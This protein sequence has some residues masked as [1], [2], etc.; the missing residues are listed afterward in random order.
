MSTP[1]RWQSN[2]PDV[3]SIDSNGRITA[4]NAG[5]VVITALSG[6]HQASQTVVV[7]PRADAA[8]IVTPPPPP[9][10]VVGFTESVRG[11]L[12]AFSA[13]IRTDSISTIRGKITQQLADDL[14]RRIAGVR[15]GE[16][17]VTIRDIVADSAR[18]TALFRMRI[19]DAARRP[20]LDFADFR[21]TFSTSIRGWRLTSIDRIQ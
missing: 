2:D 20:L 10:T 12:A 9:P 11:A 1:V 4:K 17:N 13:A 15:A 6:G 8:K 5:S 18:A 3:A 7:Q 19:D 16:I 14:G 21:A